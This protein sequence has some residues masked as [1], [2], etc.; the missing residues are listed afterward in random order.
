MVMQ[1]GREAKNRLKGESVLGQDA[2]RASDIHLEE[3]PHKEFSIICPIEQASLPGTV[4]IEDEINT[5]SSRRNE[6]KCEEKMGIKSPDHQ[7]LRDGITT[8]VS[9]S[10]QNPAGHTVQIELRVLKIGID[11]TEAP[12]EGTLKAEASDG[13][14][15]HVPIGEAISGGTQTGMKRFMKRRRKIASKAEK[16]ESISMESERP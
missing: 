13:T 8:G 14:T 4:V 3:M 16:I 6:M 9:H 10:A 15:G 5:A 12:R 2:V 7:S 11:S 1:E